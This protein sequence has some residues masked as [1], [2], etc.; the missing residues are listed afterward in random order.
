[1]ATSN[2]EN[3]RR[4]AKQN[5]DRIQEYRSRWYKK[6]R[7]G[8]VLERKLTTEVHDE[9]TFYALSGEF[10]M[11]IDCDPEAILLAGE[12]YKLMYRFLR[13]LPVR[14]AKILIE[15]FIHE[16]PTEEIGMDFHITRS[17]VDGL[18][19]GV[20]IGYADEKERIF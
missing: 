14:T 8:D 15:R 18:I 11:G 2:A 16:R 1:M 12:R 7:I 20:A 17:M 4:W 19:Q 5:P 3:Y 10:S 13:T 9:T 6:K